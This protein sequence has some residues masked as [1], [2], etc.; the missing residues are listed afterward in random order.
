DIDLMELAEAA[1]LRPLVAEHRPR[2]EELQ[3][4]ALRQTVRQHRADEARSVFRSQRDL[5]AAAI[6]EGVHFFRDD[7][8]A[9][10]D[11][12]R[13]DF[14]EFEDRRRD[15]LEAIA[16]GN[17]ARRVDHGAMPAL[18][19]GEWILGAAYR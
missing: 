1:F 16:L 6:G 19:V 12:P 4:Q 5:F 18:R 2:G 3:R 14:G 11:R 7:I 8:R 10:A 13:E 17:A 9:L 15:F